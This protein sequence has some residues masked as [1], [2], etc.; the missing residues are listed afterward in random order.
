MYTL[1]AG[2][3]DLDF[4]TTA[5]HNLSNLPLT[6]AVT[7]LFVYRIFPL[8]FQKRIWTFISLTILIF[9]VAILLRR[10][11][12]QLFQF[13]W[14]YSDADYTFTFFN[15]YRMAGH[16]MQLGTTVGLVTGLKY[17]RDW[18][19]TKDKVEALNAEKR[20]AELSFLKAQV[21]PHFLFNTLNSIYYEVIKKSESA[22]DLIIHLSD[23]LRFT[24]YECKDPLIPIAKEVELIQ[25]YIALEERRYGERL[26]VAFEVTGDTTALTP[27]LICFS[28]V[29]NAFK[30][31]TSHN[32]DHS[33]I[34]IMLNISTEKLRLEVRNP[35]VNFQPTD[36]FGA[37]EGIGL[38][39]ITHQLELTFE[40]NYRLVT[41]PRGQA[42]VSILE[43]PLN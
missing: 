9:V 37:S 5:L 21:H 42:F 2:L 23:I 8:Y 14:L 15:W 10:F 12:M 26:S 39:N 4:G 1:S 18:Q 11:S 36:E 13:Q 20:K 3:Y 28:L 25:N 35:I 38:Q 17:F 24:L 32:K 22:P 30:H 40:K 41:E 31:G 7:Y 29:E 43:I 34:E 19:R 27:P 16:L 6:M 33:H